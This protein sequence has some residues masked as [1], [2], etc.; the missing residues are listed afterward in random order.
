MAWTIAAALVAAEDG[1]STIAGAG[2]VAV[3]YPSFF[4]DLAA[5]VEWI[6][7]SRRPGRG[8]SKWSR[9]G[10]VPIASTTLRSRTSMITG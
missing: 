2:C 9:R 7:L 3:S 8:Y 1:E 5:L 6:A 4:D 10:G